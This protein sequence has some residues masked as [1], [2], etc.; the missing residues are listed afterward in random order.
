[1]TTPTGIRR[2][3]QNTSLLLNTNDT[4]EASDTSE[5]NREITREETDK[6]TGAKPSVE[7][8]IDNSLKRIKTVT[9]EQAKVP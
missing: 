4:N 8:E 3:T 9:K 6:P 5:A 2:R 7:L 1:M